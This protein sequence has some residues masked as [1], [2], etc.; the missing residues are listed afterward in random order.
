[1]RSLL[2][3][4]PLLACARDPGPT[5]PRASHSTGNA[6]DLRAL[7]YAAADPGADRRQRGVTLYDRARSV[8][9]WTLLGELDGPHLLALDSEG[10]QVAS[11]ST[12]GFD[13][14]EL[15]LLLDGQRVLLL[16]TDQ[17]VALLERDGTLLWKTPLACHHDLW[18]LPEGDLWVPV[19]T[20]RRWRG[21]RV[22]FDAIQ[23]LD[24]QGRL[25]ERVDLFELRDRL[26]PLHAPTPLDGESAQAGD[27]IYD[28]YHLNAFSIVPEDSPWL[29][30]AW[31]LCLR[32]VDLIVALDPRTREVLWSLGPGILDAPHHARVTSGGHLLVFDNGRHRGWSRVVE[33]DPESGEVVWEYRRQGF[34]SPVR[35][36]AQRL[37]GGNTLITE[38]ERGH[39]FEV[40]PAGELV[41]EWWNPLFEAK[42]RRRVY[43]ALR[44]LP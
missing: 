43:R 2:F 9:G 27:E 44:S 5:T 36:A 24:G 23:H 7:G 32:N 14:V 10:R 3:C 17:G 13:R 34:F 11:W 41:W 19:H 21:R 28:Y 16:S 4:L 15:G 12:P 35:G 1:M 29:P 31:L 22:R 25:L 42:G 37:R 30:G 40:T 26:T 38:S 39:V 6:Q 20:E 18:P 8:P 33:F